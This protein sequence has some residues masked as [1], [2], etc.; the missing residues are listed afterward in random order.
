[1]V[2]T[3]EYGPRFHT[4]LRVS[5]HKGGVVPAAPA[6][7]ADPKL[8][9]PAQQRRR[10]WQLHASLVDE[11]HVARPVRACVRVRLLY[12]HVCVCVCVRVCVCAMLRVGTCGGGCFLRDGALEAGCDGL[13]RRALCEVGSL[14]AAALGHPWPANSARAQLRL[15]SGLSSESVVEEAEIVTSLPPGFSCELAWKRHQGRR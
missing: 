2:S 5:Q 13:V 3:W 9:C 10:R 14:A 4:C 7:A 8:G 12:V 11:H 15:C 1:M 6:V